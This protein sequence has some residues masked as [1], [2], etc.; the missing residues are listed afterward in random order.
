M[1][2]EYEINQYTCK[3]IKFKLFLIKDEILISCEFALIK[4]NVVCHLFPVTVP[5]QI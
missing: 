1:R 2:I 4:K 5:Q 3:S